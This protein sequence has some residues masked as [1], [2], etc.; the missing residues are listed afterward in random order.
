MTMA[1][2]DDCVGHWR[3]TEMDAWPARVVYS[4]WLSGKLSCRGQ[5]WWH[6]AQM[7]RDR[8]GA[9]LD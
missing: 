1:N 5:G 2:R 8:A 3:L 9:I 6:D 4:A 7:V